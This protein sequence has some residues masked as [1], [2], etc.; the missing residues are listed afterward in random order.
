ME[1]M[2][3]KTYQ[4]M[5]KEELWQEIK[6]IVNATQFTAIDKELFLDCIK[7]WGEKNDN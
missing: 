4:Q 7:E 6:T 5:T 1:K 2:E 3:N